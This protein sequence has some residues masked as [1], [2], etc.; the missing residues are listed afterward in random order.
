MATK[1][2]G[3]EFWGLNMST[4]PLIVQ[5]R[6][7]PDSTMVLTAIRTDNQVRDWGTVVDCFLFG[8]SPRVEGMVPVLVAVVLKGRKVA[9]D[10]P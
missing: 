3:L 7:M 2:L 10:C 1:C 8:S 9:P 5:R 4:I 6:S